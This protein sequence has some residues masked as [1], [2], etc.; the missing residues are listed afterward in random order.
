MFQSLP[1]PEVPQR[2]T[3]RV[4]VVD[5]EPTLC[6]AFSFALKNATTLVDTAPSGATALRML[7]DEK[8]DAVFLDLRMPD[9]NGIDVLRELRKTGNKIP[10]V[11]CSAFFTVEAV[12]AAVSQQVADF[13]LKPVRPADLRSALAHLFEPPFYEISHA[14]ALIREGRFDQALETLD[15]IEDARAR[16]WRSIIAASRTEGGDQENF[17]GILGDDVA[18]RIAFSPPHG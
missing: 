8:Y 2:G 5:D 6:F 13:V 10:V 18:A 16:I 12:I 15:S 9:I 11:M 1:Q 14:L 4:L 7:A 17:R 3:K